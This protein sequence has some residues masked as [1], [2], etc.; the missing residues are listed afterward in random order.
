MA[1]FLEF[2]LRVFGLKT[3]WNSKILAL[4]SKFLRLTLYYRIL[5]VIIYAWI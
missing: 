1:N 5:R 3:F 4:A 2:F